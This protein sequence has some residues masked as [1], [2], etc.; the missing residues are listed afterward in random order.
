MIMLSPAER[1]PRISVITP[2]YNQAR[3]IEQTIQSVLSQ[4]Y[5]HLEYL[6]IDGGSTDGTLDILRR[7][8]DHLTWISE[9]DSGQTN[10]INKGLR[11]AS[12]EIVAY[13]NADDLYEPDT[14]FLV[15]KYFNSNS[16][17]MCVT[18]QCQNIDEKGKI[19][20]RGV[21][22][23]KNFWLR[24]GNYSVLQVLNF[25]AQPATFWRRCILEQIGY[26]DER[27]HYTMDYEY[28][29]RIGKHYPIHRL[30][31][32]LAQFRI[33][34]NSKSGQTSTDQFNEELL[35][36]MCYGKGLPILLHKLHRI[37]TVQVYLHYFRQGQRKRAHA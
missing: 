3:F 23:Y 21:S 11:M 20:R 18:G 35:V 31:R 27:L 1:L 33:H 12:G 5:P 9:Q 10:A 24:V 26:L 6:I 14:L 15:G 34:S 25:I 19:I 22:W 29:L 7:Y 4:N 16:D 32:P 36:A 28:W 8:N 30:H 13:L 2:S 37:A 17:A